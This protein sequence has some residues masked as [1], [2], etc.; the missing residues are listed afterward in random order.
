MSTL[1][2]LRLRIRSIKQTQKIT[3]AM[4]MV[5]GAKLR[6]FQKIS[7]NANIYGSALKKVITKALI[8]KED[9]D[10]PD[11]F[12]IDAFN[13][14]TLIVVFTS[15]RGLCSN[16]NSSIIKLAKQ[17][18]NNLTTHKKP[19]SIIC[20][21][22]RGYENLRKTMPSIL[23]Y[24]PFND[25]ADEL[26][27]KI[28][29]LK[30]LLKSYINNKEFNDIVFCYGKFVNPLKQ[31]PTAQTIFPFTPETLDPAPYL[32]AFDEDAKSF[33]TSAF[34]QYLESIIHQTYFES[35]ASENAA[36][37]TSMDNASRNADEMIKSLQIHYNTSRQFSITREL[38]EIISGANATQ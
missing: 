26:N 27:L 1:K 31:E 11:Y 5:S 17:V 15:N 37:M 2:E 35:L 30:D 25:K 34:E 32:Y 22:Q 14:K 18:T 28:D 38:I 9:L 16:F 33:L 36:R 29:H 3:T 13:K 19:F 21:G 20:V 10:I 23:Y 24:Q 7:E 4:K 8:Q 12:D 6:R